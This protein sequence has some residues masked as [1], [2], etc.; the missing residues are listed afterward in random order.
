MYPGSMTKKAD[1]AHVLQ[2][3]LVVFGSDADHIAI[4][5]G[6][7][8]PAGTCPDTPDAE[9]ITAVL[10]LGCANESRT[11]VASGAID[12]DVDVFAD[13]DG[14]IQALPVAA[15]TYYCVGKSLEAATTDGDEMQ[16]DP[17]KPYPVVVT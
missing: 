3:L 16:V 6:T 11:M 14:K 15:G 10:L 7:A 8:A 9:E 12:V 17:C 1:A 13:A 5:D 4:C 2:Y